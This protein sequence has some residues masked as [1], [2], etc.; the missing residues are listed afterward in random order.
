MAA[1][2]VPDNA[3]AHLHLHSV[4]SLLDGACKIDELIEHIKSLGQKSVAITDHGN[5]YAA[6]IFAQAAEKAGIHA[7]I[8]CEVYVAARTRFDRENALDRKSDHLILL[9]E[10]E[11]G[12]RNLVKLVT[13]SNI[14]GFYHRPRVDEELLREY[15]D[16]LICLS[17]CIAGKLARLILSDDYEKAKQTALM[18]RDIF[19]EENY[20]IEIQ[21]HGIKD[22][23]K[24][25][26]SLY[27]L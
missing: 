6:V 15:S 12:Y 5:L 2:N 16:G 10:N 7:V 1:S 27:R 4:Y 25:L 9:C 23:I 3:F 17:G 22:E 24:V 14:E 13:K 19:G 18:Y 20:F 8:G 11:T 21:N 26:P